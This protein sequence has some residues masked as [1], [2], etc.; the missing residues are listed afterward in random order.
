MQ[1]F[2]MVKK[3]IDGMVK[4]HQALTKR[5]ELSDELLKKKDEEVQGWKENVKT[6][7]EFALSQDWSKN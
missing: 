3:G 6:L 5:L 2:V 4:G 7:E 1:H